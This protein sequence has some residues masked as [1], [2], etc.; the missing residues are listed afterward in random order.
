MFEVSDKIVCINTKGLDELSFLFS[1]LPIEGQMYVVRWMD[2]H[3]ETLKPDDVPGVL[4]VGIFGGDWY[5]TGQE[6]SFNAKRFV[7]LDEYRK[8]REH[9]RTLFGSAAKEIPIP[10]K[11]HLEALVPA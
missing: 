2:F 10:N 11:E 5:K 9:Y 4:L 7:K 6:F 1:E 8:N 3:P